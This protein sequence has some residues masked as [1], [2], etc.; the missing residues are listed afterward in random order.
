MSE[1]GRDLP[2]RMVPMEINTKL[3][4]ASWGHS[5][6]MLGICEMDNCMFFFLFYLRGTSFLCERNKEEWVGFE[7]FVKQ[8]WF[9]Q[10]NWFGE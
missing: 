9:G 2:A 6:V 4:S 5:A 8:G 3:V 1:L 10:R 7:R